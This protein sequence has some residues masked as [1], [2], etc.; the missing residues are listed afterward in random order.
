MILDWYERCA[1]A[2]V[3]WVLLFRPWPWKFRTNI[4]QIEMSAG[5]WFPLLS[6]K[7]HHWYIFNPTMAMKFARRFWLQVWARTAVCMFGPGW[8]N[9]SMTLQ[10][11]IDLAE[12]F[13]KKLCRNFRR[14]RTWSSE[15]WLVPNC[16]TRASCEPPLG[17]ESAPAALQAMG[18]MSSSKVASWMADTF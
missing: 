1:V 17:A 9:A 2:P 3:Q 12:S 15:T 13:W 4:A 10:P 5:P 16:S 7:K 6:K 8:M 18:S 14:R 11:W